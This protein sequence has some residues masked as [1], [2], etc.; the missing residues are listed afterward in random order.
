MQDFFAE[1]IGFGR[2]ASKSTGEVFVLDRRYFDQILH[3]NAG[4]RNRYAKAFSDWTAEL[5]KSGS[6]PDKIRLDRILTAVTV[7][8]DDIVQELF[9][10]VLGYITDG[11]PSCHLPGKISFKETLSEAPPPELKGHLTTISKFW[12]RLALPEA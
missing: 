2:Y 10:R 9:D 6:S 11:F 12:A 5:E 8:G 3:R 1:E 7:M 4:F